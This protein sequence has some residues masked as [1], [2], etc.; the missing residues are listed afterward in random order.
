[1]R[2]AAKA[3]S[4]CLERVAFNMV[5]AFL[6]GERAADVPDGL[7]Q[8]VVRPCGD[9]PQQRPDRRERHLGRVGVRAVRTPLFTL[10]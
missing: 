2:R 5:H 8:V 1:M 4:E 7:P 10:F 6:R 9:L 3:G